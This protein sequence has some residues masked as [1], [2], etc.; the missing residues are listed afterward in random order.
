MFVVCC[1][2]SLHAQEYKISVQNTQE[3]K[4][5]LNDFSND[6]PVEGYNGTEII[7]TSDRPSK[8]PSRAKGLQAVYAAGTDNTGIGVSVEKMA[9]R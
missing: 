9:T 7:I 6:L 5:T 8:P 1:A 2:T 3:G 4:L